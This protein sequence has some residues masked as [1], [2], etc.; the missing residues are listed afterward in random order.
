MA[1]CT[2]Y[3]SSPLFLQPYAA[4]STGV[5]TVPVSV[6][7]LIFKM[8]YVKISLAVRWEVSIVGLEIFT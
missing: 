3:S 7:K 8:S 2:H 1:V 4:D 6:A 5:L